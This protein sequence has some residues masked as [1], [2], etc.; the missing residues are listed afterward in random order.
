MIP[1]YSNIEDLILLIKYYLEYKD[2]RLELVKQ[3]QEIAIL[4]YSYELQLMRLIELC[5]KH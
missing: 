4:K 5:T 3:M 2:E 1:Y